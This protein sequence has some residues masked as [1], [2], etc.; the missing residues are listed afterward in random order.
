[1]FHPEFRILFTH[2][3]H[4][5]LLD[6]INTDI[7]SVIFVCGFNVCSILTFCFGVYKMISFGFFYVG[8]LMKF[9][10]ENLTPGNELLEITI[11]LSS[12]V[13]S[14]LMFSTMKAISDL[15]DVRFVKLKNDIKMKDEY[16]EELEEIIATKNALIIKMHDKAITKLEESITKLKEDVI[17]NSVESEL[18]SWNTG[19]I[20]E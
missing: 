18:A 7:V 8:L 13:V 14:G 11:I 3:A 16:I 20:L 4:N 17:D 15:L 19:K 12:L 9:I 10:W 2:E 6:E 5:Q 1:M